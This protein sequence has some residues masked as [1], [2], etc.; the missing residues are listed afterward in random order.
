MNKKLVTIGIALTLTL[1]GCSTQRD[2]TNNTDNIEPTRYNEQMNRANDG[3][4]PGDGTIY[5]RGVGDEAR[6]NGDDMNRHERTGNYSVS[7][8]AADR[9]V[10][11]MDDIDQAYVL[12]TNRNAYVAALLDTDRAQE[13][14][15]DQTN[16]DI[17]E[18]TTEE[19]H[20]LTDDVKNKISEI[21][22]SVDSNIDNVYITT[23]P[24]FADLINNYMA[25]VDAG[26]PVRGFFDQFGNMIERIFPQNKS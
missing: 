9:I 10:D 21:V 26:K 4:R 14:M 13:R 15:D 12:M 18:N 19:G 3:N 11:Q 17:A 20:I 5:P 8:E 7:E 6:D 25:D 16:Y 2:D 24:D 22:Q 23:N 1:V